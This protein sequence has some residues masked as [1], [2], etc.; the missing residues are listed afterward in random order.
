M[1]ESTK[2]AAS[3]YKMNQY[4][5]VVHKHALE[6]K[7]NALPAN[8]S[9]HSAH[10]LG[11]MSME[12]TTSHKVHHIDLSMKLPKTFSQEDTSQYENEVAEDF[13]GSM[14]EATLDGNRSSLLM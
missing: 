12:T 9:V 5:D 8:S 2:R 13:N 10:S 1:T 6:E 11:S 7:L 4:H 3:K 14:D